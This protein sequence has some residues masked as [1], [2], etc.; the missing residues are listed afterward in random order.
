MI[1]QILDGDIRDG[2]YAGNA[3]TT[4]NPFITKVVLDLNAPRIVYGARNNYV[5]ASAITVGT[6]GEISYVKSS[7]ST[8]MM[9]WSGTLPLNIT[10]AG[11]GGLDT[12]VEAANTWYAVYIIGDSTGANTPNTLLSVS[13]TAPTLPIGYDKFRRVGA[14]RNNGS[15]DFLIFLSNDKGI[16]RQVWYTQA[17][18]GNILAGGSATVRTTISCS[19][20]IP[21]TSRQIN[22]NCQFRN[23]LAGAAA[24][25][26][27][28]LFVTGVAAFI[29]EWF[30]TAGIKLTSINGTVTPQV[31]PTDVSQNIDYSLANTNDRLT[32]FVQGYKDEL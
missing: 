11:V 12:G 20:F 16:S 28:I 22:L 26:F 18:V 6:T 29:P 30:G 31:M 21:P 32:L 10:T 3:P 8:L 14:V 5:S 24:T 27:F 2:L 25:D 23:D 15:G 7:D 1:N 13:F 4:A 17:V 19:A 9:S